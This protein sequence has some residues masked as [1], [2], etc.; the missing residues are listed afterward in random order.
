MTIKQGTHAPFRFP[1]LITTTE[2]VRVVQFTPSCRYDIGVNQKELNK[3]IGVGYFPHHSRNSVGFSWR[4]D[5]ASDM[6]EVIAHWFDHGEEY[7][8]PI[9]FV[10]IG[11]KN[12]LVMR[13]HDIMHELFIGKDRV[14]IDLPACEL[15]V[16]F[17][18]SFGVF[19]TAPHNITI[20]IKKLK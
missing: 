1:V 14:L 7:Q 11:S 9:K 8:L 20:N 17:Q 12:T 13:R 19:K 4:Y 6:I 3:L 16:L 5:L 2:I 10:A 15:G 18:P